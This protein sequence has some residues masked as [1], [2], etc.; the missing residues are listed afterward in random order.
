MNRGEISQGKRR[1]NDHPEAWAAAEVPGTLLTSWARCPTACYRLYALANTSPAKPGLV[2]D[3]AG[4]GG[5]EVKVWE[6]DEETFGSFVASIPAPLGVGTITLAGSIG[7]TRPHSPNELNQSEWHEVCKVRRIT[8]LGFR[9]SE[10]QVRERLS[11]LAK[12]RDGATAG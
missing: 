8:P 7:A 10:R 4:P 3:G 5:V 6:L 9:L 11:R 12:Q 2:F 1:V